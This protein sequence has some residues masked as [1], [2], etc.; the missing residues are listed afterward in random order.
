VLLRSSKRILAVLV[1]NCNAYKM[2]ILGLE[3]NGLG[4]EM[5]FARRGRGTKRCKRNFPNKEKGM[6]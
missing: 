6:F 3:R 5:N 2:N 1:I 4:L